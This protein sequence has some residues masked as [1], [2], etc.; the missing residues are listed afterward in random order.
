MKK[1]IFLFLS[2][3]LTLTIISCGDEKEEFTATTTTTNDNT[4]SSAVTVSGKVQKGPRS[5]MLNKSK[6]ADLVKMSLFLKKHSKKPPTSPNR[7]LR[8][9]ANL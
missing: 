3:F 9:Y 6:H 2:T 7:C 8:R 1:I 5:K 4:T